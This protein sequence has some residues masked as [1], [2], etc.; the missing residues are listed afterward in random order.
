MQPKKTMLTYIIIG[1]VILSLIFIIKSN[2]N[3]NPKP[4]SKLSKKSD[5][6]VTTSELISKTEERIAS[7]EALLAEIRENK[8]KET[9]IKC[10]VSPH[11]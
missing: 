11:C 2:N 5:D 4:K 6:Y 3:P 9:I 7:S 8:G 10:K 1:I